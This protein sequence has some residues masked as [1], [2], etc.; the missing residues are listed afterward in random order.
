M[1][2]LKTF[3]SG[4][5]HP[6][7]N[8][9]S[10]ESSIEVFPLPKQATIPVNQN[11]GAPSVP[12]VSKGDAV[13]TGQLIAK[14]EAFISSNVH[15]SVSGKVLKID[16]MI[17]QTG[18]RRKAVVINVE[19][20]EW[21]PSVDRSPGIRSEITLSREEIIKKI[22]EMGIVGMGGATFPSHVK[23]MVPEGKKAEYL[24]INGVECEP[25]LTADH[26][27]MLEKGEE[28]LVGTRILMKGL[29]VEKAIIGIE[30]NKPD[31]I[32][33]LTELSKKYSN[34]S[35][36]ALKVKYPQGGE[37][38][39]INALLG[40]EVPSGK[41]PIEV[42][43]VVN[44]VGTA[45]AVYEAVQKNKPLIE[46]VVTV[47]GK[48][49][50]KPSNF[51]VRIGTPVQELL[52]RA[53]SGLEKTGKVVSGG[54][55]MGKALNSLEVPVVKGTSGLLLF[56][57]ENA[58]RIVLKACIRC[59]RCVK[60]CPMGLEPILLAQFSEKSM[61]DMAEANLV[62]DCM[63]CGSCH[64]TCPSGRPLL[65]YIR[66]GKNKVGQN[67]RNRGKK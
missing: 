45:F 22:H 34:I 57:E 26:R 51:L 40:R 11:L 9:L 64:Y 36:Q 27:L 61:W 17:D 1:C 55:M 12:L 10:T 58:S 6:P 49:V 25:Y 43:C 41:L 47:T 19:G 13:K 30:N 16:E 35:V 14:G 7:E 46:R 67:I 37:K 39:L 44:N 24:I 65:D 50:K 66:L 8:K 38:Q 21:E 60:V 63:E 42:G 5:V 31:A 56:T 20:D 18:F 2:A 15:S 53:Q 32:R 59:G 4:G 28:V 48:T 62:M 29:G 52:E 23:L 54:P 3:H 33:N